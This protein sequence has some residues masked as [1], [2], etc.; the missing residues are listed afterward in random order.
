M[1]NKKEPLSL[2]TIK[3][4]LAVIIFTGV[5]TIIVGGGWLIG[6]NYENK[7]NDKIVKPVD[8][9]M[10]KCVKEGEKFYLK[11]GEPQTKECCSNLKTGAFYSIIDDKCIPET[12]ASICIDCPNGICGPGENKCNCPE[13]CKE[14]IDTADW[15]TYRNEEYGFEIILLDSWAGYSTL[16][17]SWNGITLDNNSAKYEG[18]KIIIRNPNWSDNEIWQ[19]IP[20]LV[21]TKYEWQ[22]VEQGNLNISAAPVEPEKLGENEKYIF[23]LPPR[24]IG[25]SDALG[26][27]EAREI[28]KTF[29][30]ISFSLNETANWKTYRNE[31]YGFELKYPKDW[32]HESDVMSETFFQKFNRDSNEFVCRFSVSMIL[33]EYFDKYVKDYYPNSYQETEINIGEISAIKVDD[34]LGSNYFIKRKDKKGYSVHIFSV[35]E[36]FIHSEDGSGKVTSGS[37]DNPEC[38]KNF[39][40]ILSTFKFIE[41]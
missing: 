30:A 15:K 10:R 28:I 11:P 33:S 39:N 24:W 19:D 41:K 21:F 25:F 3:T 16:T 23:A 6:N 36:K 26:Q 32:K 34:V 22:L 31:K 5:G 13:D 7:T 9:E 29:K 1:P 12:V 8:Q 18:P 35:I 37:L 20:I 38:L 14:E 40:Q 2:I 17:E 27:N 4:L